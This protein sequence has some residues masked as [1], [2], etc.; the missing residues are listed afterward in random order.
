MSDHIISPAMFGAISGLSPREVFMC[1]LNLLER[2]LDGH[3]R[4]QPGAIHL[5]N[6]EVFGDGEVRFKL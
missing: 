4:T 1:V 5:Q 3:S 2:V 6:G